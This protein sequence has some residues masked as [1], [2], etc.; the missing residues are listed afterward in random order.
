MIE[1]EIK[2]G[3]GK[4]KIGGINKYT[5]ITEWIGGI[6][7]GEDIIKMGLDD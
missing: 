7:M 2:R 4:K 5:R 3:R 1:V 6:R